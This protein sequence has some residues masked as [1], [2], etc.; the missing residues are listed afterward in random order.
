MKKVLILLLASMLTL[1]ALA[2]P[3]LVAAASDL[4]Y[5][6]DE[7]VA[8]YRKTA[9]DVEPKVSLGASGNFFAQ[10][11]NGAPFDVLLSADMD[12]PRELAKLGAA[13][14]ATLTPYAIGR[15]A[16]WSL[17]PQVDPHRGLAA[18]VADARVKRVAIANP[19]TA[20]YGRAAKAL[21][22]LDGLWDKVQPKLVIGE[23]IAQTAQFVQTGNAQVGI[24]SYATLHATKLKGVGRFALMPQ[25]GLA[26]LEQGAI[27]TRAG[28][29]NPH[30]L[31]FVRFLGSPA[32]R[33]ILA[34]NGFALSTGTRE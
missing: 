17:D 24:V 7:L 27:V 8:A 18:L 12:Y 9:P 5:C 29:G 4:G 26:P 2:R 6:I 30:A 21:L 16:L 19:A 20:P 23:N 15:L 1:P 25:D 11:R 31:G 3:L 10:I 13:D 28:A 14:G 33:A 32:A 22:E 34:R